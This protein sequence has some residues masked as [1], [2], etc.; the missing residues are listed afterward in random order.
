MGGNHQVE[1]H[2]HR[3]D[4]STA[5]HDPIVPIILELEIRRG[6]AR[7]S[8]VEP[9]L[10]L[11]VDVH[12]PLFFIVSAAADIVV[13]A[14]LD[15]FG[16]RYASVPERGFGGH[17]ERVVDV[18]RVGEDREVEREEPALAAWDDAEVRGAQ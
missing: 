4:V 1:G 17:E 14:I 8:R 12:V 13:G 7:P 15:R 2:A 11:R 6:C 16:P 9:A 18:P 3:P 5:Q 10:R